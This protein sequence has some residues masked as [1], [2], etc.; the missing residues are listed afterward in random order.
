MNLCVAIVVLTAV[1]CTSAEIPHETVYVLGCLEKTKVEAEAALQVDGEEVIYADFQSGQEVW[2][3]PEFLGPF[4]S[5]TVRNF[6]KNAV[7]GRRL[8]RDALALW[9]LEEKRPPEVK[10]APESTIYPRDEEEL[11]VENTLICF[12]NHFYPPPVKVNWTK[13]GLEVT[14]GASLSRYY[15]NEDGT[16]HQLSSLSFTPQEGD[17]YA[18]TVEHT[19]LEDPKTRFWDGY[20]G[21]FEM[22]CRFSSEDP[23]DIEF[24]L[25]VYGNKKLLGQYNST[26]EKCTVYTQWM[27]NFTET[28]CKGPAFLAARREEMKKYCS[29]NVPVVYG[30][31]LDKAVEPYIRLRSVEPFSTR[32]LAMLVC[33]AY[34]FYPK[35]IRVTWLRDGQE[36]T[37]NVTS[38]EELVNGDWT[39]QIHSHLEYTPTP[40]ERITCM[41]EHFSLT[42]PKLYDWDPSM[43]G[44][45]RN[46]MVIGACGLLLGVVF[47]AAGLIYYRKKSTEGRML[48]PT[49]ALPE[50]YG[51]I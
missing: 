36:V 38:T 21:R 1:V 2:T 22:R 6:Y 11:G 13:N 20:F 24:L 37:S 49:M 19:A 27:K 45:E 28:A 41:V 35:P 17:V 42:E 30:Y 32:H 3:L 16:F 39:Y 47:I 34:D 18:C 12:A 25:Q 23:R 31:L 10:D 5:S 14:E 26:T 29:S 4:P 15:P 46:K 40:G 9:I 44:P 33:S 8:C 50:S 7:K 51:T 48:V 43:P